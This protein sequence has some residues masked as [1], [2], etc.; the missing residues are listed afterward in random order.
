MTDPSLEPLVTYLREHSGG[1]SVEILREQLLQNGNDPATVD[2]AITIYQQG[3]LPQSGMPGQS[4][5]SRY[6][7]LTCLGLAVLLALI[8]LAVGWFCLTTSP[9]K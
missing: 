2:R 7:L 4:K 6:V 9:L 3:G 1:Y 8:I 5:T